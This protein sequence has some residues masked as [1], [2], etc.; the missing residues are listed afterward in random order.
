MA[1]RNRVRESN[2]SDPVLIEHRQFLT[3]SVDMLSSL[4]S[5]SSRYDCG[6]LTT[7]LRDAAREAQRMSDRS[8]NH[9]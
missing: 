1:A 8:V 5:L 3:Y 4:A 9:P 2:S 6:K 7:L